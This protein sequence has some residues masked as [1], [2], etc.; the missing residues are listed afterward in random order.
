MKTFITSILILV[1]TVSY[2]QQVNYRKLFKLDS[3][4]S[5]K[6]EYFIGKLAERLKTAKYEYIRIEYYDVN[7]DEGTFR[8][9]RVFTKEHPT[10]YWYNMES[11]EYYLINKKK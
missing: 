1:A 2:S 4:T 8:W 10:G 5:G 3:V 9:C 6:H 11:F 7:E